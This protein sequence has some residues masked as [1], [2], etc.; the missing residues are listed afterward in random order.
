M[1]DLSFEKL[2]PSE[3]QIALAYAKL[4]RQ[5]WEE[6]EKS[7]DLPYSFFY[8]HIEASGRESGCYRYCSESSD[9]KEAADALMERLSELAGVRIICCNNRKMDICFM[10][11][12]QAD[13]NCSAQTADL[14]R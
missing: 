10:R 14:A 2:S 3:Q 4:V 5:G 1:P 7:L 9:P 12:E 11:K 13:G 8:G 6:I